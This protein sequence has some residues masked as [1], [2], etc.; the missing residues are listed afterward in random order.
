MRQM[1]DLKRVAIVILTYNNIE[2][3]KTCLES[4]RKHTDEGTYEIVVVDNNSTDGT[5]EWLREQAD[6]KLQL[7]DKNEG[8]PRGCNTGIGMAG[9]DCDILLLNNDTI[10]TPNWLSNLQQCLYSSESTGAVG[11]VCNH[12]ENL[13]GIDY[14]YD[15]LDEMADFA[16]KN[17]VSD[18]GRWEEKIFL[19]GFCI[20]IKREVLNKTGP[21]D[22][23]YSPGYV[24]D[25][26]LCLRIIDAGY[27][28]MLCHDC[29]IHHYLGSGF[30]KDLSRFYP[31]LYA[32]REYFKNKWGFETPAFDDVQFASLRIIN[33]PDKY[34]KMNVL[35]LGCGIGVTL[36]KVRY[37]YPNAVLYGLEQNKKM[38]EIAKHVANVSVGQGPVD[39]N[40]DFFDYILI[41]NRLETAEDPDAFLA[42]IKNY[43]KPGGFIIGTVQNIMHY[44]VIRSVL[45]GSWL[46]A[47][48]TVS[49]SNRTFFAKDD[50]IRLF[51]KCGY[52]SP[53]IFHWFSV[54][55][56]EDMAFIQKISAAGLEKSEYLYTTYLYSF[57]FQK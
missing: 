19:I 23:K 31:V 53:Y 25:N 51:L 16:E 49:K 14:Y 37:D 11:A 3:S 43:L 7:N 20:L 9:K 22:E 38:A 27:R 18:S 46:Y 54:P 5:K 24:E 34:K 10:V 21:L 32:N 47:G 6:I 29:F 39:F 28:L 8:F 45:S 41:G 55:S 36:L 35:E 17:N 44:S 26:D 57:K 13:Q 52:A 30:R 33:E 42:E 56:E 12:N 1:H 2:Y 50:I 48:D 40:K 4:I 15:D